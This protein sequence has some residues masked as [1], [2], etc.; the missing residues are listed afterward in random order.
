MKNELDQEMV[1]AMLDRLYTLIRERGIRKTDVPKALGISMTTFSDWRRGKGF[2]S[3]K[4]T[5]KFCEYFDVSLDWL[6]FGKEPE[7]VEK[8]VDIVDISVSR[9]TSII[10]RFRKL[11]PPLQDR[12]LSYADGMIATMPIPESSEKRLQA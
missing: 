1:D 2:P 10:E 9:E 5:I 4:N 6:V 7:T 8:S 12:L 11:T 3:L